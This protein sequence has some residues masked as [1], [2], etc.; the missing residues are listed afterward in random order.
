MLWFLL[1][2]V[3][4]V[5]AGAVLGYLARN[6]YRKAKALMREA[7]TASDQLSEITAAMDASTA[8]RESRRSDL[9]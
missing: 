2:L 8:P 5:A 4:V 1:W 3:L 9:R 7:A 6:L